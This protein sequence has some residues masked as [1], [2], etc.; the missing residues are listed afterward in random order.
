MRTHARAFCREGVRGAVHDVVDPTGPSATS[1]SV[2]PTSGRRHV[3]TSPLAVSA[4][5]WVLA[6]V[7]RHL[8]GTGRLRRAMARSS[9]LAFMLQGPVLVGLAWP[10]I[11]R[12]TLGRFI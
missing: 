7:Q 9:Y 1:A 8:S 10:L 11:T 2:T 5:I 3:R 6:F 4:S 12:T